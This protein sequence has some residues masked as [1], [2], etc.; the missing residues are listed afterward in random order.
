MPLRRSGCP[1][2]GEAATSVVRSLPYGRNPVVLPPELPAFALDQVPHSRMPRLR[3]A[4]PGGGA[5]PRGD[6]G[7]LSREAEPVADP[8]GFAP[9]S[10]SRASRRG[11]AAGAQT[12]RPRGSARPGF[13]GGRLRLGRHRPCA[14]LPRDLPRFARRHRRMRGQLRAQG[15]GDRGDRA[16][17]ARL[18]QRRSGLR[19]P[20]ASARAIARTRAQAAARRPDQDQHAGRPRG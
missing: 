15:G 17:L 13:R 10:G 3:A 1:A 6:G 4:L 2:C 14:G 7:L 16:R 19:A 12:H 11:C 20:G 9:A 5:R 8:A 18:H